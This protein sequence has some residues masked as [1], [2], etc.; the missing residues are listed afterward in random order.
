MKL[1]YS[2]VVDP[3]RKKKIWRT[4]NPIAILWIVYVSELDPSYLSSLG[5]ILLQLKDIKIWKLNEIATVCFL[6]SSIHL[7]EIVEKGLGKI[8]C[9]EYNFRLFRAETNYT[10]AIYTLAHKDN[11]RNNNISHNKLLNADACTQTHA[12][13]P[14]RQRPK[15]TEKLLANFSFW[16]A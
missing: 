10:F 13:K 16:F 15:M 1:N 6:L 8:S 9:H 4:M 14:D 3:E 7:V 2:I 12:P 5:S 11:S